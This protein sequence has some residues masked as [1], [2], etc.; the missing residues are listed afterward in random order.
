[1][2]FWISVELCVILIANLSF[3]MSES[4]DQHAVVAAAKPTVFH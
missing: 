2:K 1:M 3:S 4:L